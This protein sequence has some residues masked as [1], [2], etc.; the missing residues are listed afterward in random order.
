[1]SFSGAPGK[2]WLRC[3]LVQRVVDN[4]AWYNPSMSVSRIGHIGGEMSHSSLTRGSAHA[5]Q[6]NELPGISHVREHS[7]PRRNP[8]PYQR[9]PMCSPVLV[10]PLRIK[11]E[12][13]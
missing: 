2:G 13:D 8:L 10:D 7:F 6:Q 1:M 5:S 4:S 12:T 9:A 11:S 3:V